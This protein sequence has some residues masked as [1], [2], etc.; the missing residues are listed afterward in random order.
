MVYQ[1][2]NVV[3]YLSTTTAWSCMCHIGT[4]FSKSPKAIRETTGVPS[5]Y[6]EKSIFQHAFKTRENITVAKFMNWLKCFPLKKES[7]KRYARE[8]RR[9]I[10]RF[11]SVLQLPFEFWG[12]SQAFK[13]SIL[14]LGKHIMWILVWLVWFCFDFSIYVK[15]YTF[16]FYSRTI[17]FEKLFAQ[18][19]TFLRLYRRKKTRPFILI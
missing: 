4:C 18:I 3:P 9:R 6:S 2:K 5:E 12:S 1:P 16:L 19:A 7:V 10:F 14:K 11:F 13:C 15:G 8:I 17:K